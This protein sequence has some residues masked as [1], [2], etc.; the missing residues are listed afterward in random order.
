VGDGDD[1]MFGGLGNDRL[2][3]GQG[4]DRF[5]LDPPPNERGSVRS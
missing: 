4:A 1:T 3:G 5:S 2:T